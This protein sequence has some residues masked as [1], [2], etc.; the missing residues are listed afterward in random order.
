MDDLLE[1]L[2]DIEIAIRAAICSVKQNDIPN[3]LYNIDHAEID[4]QRARN[5]TVSLFHH[6]KA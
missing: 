3:V 5:I 4:V 6:G 1:I 2:T